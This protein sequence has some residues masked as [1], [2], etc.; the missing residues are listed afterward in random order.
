M[1]GTLN[2]V[3]KIAKSWVNRDFNPGEGEQ[4][5]I[6]IRYVFKQAGIFVG[7]AANPTDKFLLPPGSVFGP[8]FADSF[9]GN[10]VGQEI[11]NQKDLQ[12]GDIVLFRNTYGNY[13]TGVITHVGIYIGGGEIVHRPTRSR[14]VEREPISN[15]GGLFVEGRRV[16]VT[17]MLSTQPTSPNQIDRIICIDPGH[18]GND[19]GASGPTGVREKDVTLAVALHLQTLLLPRGARVVLTRTAD[20]SVAA[21]NASDYEELSAR[22]DIANQANANFFLSIHCNS[23]E[24][25]TAHGVETYCYPGST[26]G[27]QLANTVQKQLVTLLGTNE[28]RGVKEAKFAVLNYTD[29][30]A[31]LVELA[32]ISNPTQE[33][34][35]ADL[36]KQKSF[37]EAILAGI[38]DYINL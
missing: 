28:D 27:Y 25:A 35:L 24:Q 34:M 23:Y 11:S 12:P 18:G 38:E 2:D 20:T 15:F 32:F 37:A 8:G 31:I 6:F 26:R 3:V 5:A 29:M 19:S 30:P 7:N 14:P 13:K 1:S 36:D 22:A 33:Y 16:P 10:D 9:S 21:P 4:C 17:A